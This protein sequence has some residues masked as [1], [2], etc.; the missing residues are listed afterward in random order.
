MAIGTKKVSYRVPG[1]WDITTHV[2]VENDGSESI[3]PEL[4]IMSVL[5]VIRDELKKLNML[6]HCPNTIAIPQKLDK[7]VKNTTKAKRKRKK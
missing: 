3:S 7:I 5:F 4:A 6:M 1:N 2:G